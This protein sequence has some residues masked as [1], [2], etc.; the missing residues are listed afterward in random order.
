M[1]F[2]KTISIVLVTLLASLFG[3]CFQQAPNTQQAPSAETL[4]EAASTV[5][6]VAPRVIDELYTLLAYHEDRYPLVSAHR[7]GPAPGFPENAL[8]TFERIANIH[9]VIIECDIQMT[10]DSVLILMHDDKLDRTTDAKGRIADMDY[11][12]LAGVRLRDKDG[13]STDYRIPTLAEALQWG[14]GKV[15]YTLDVKRGVPYQLVVDEIRRNKAEA[16]SVV[17]TYNADQAAEVHALAPELMISASIRSEADL[18]RLNRMGIPNH[19][20]VAFVGT[21][22]ADRATYETLHRAGIS[23]ILGTIGNLDTQAA[24]QGEQRYVQYVRHGADIL[25]TDRP[26]EAGNALQQLAAEKGLSSPFIH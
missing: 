3:A 26:V 25:S 23:T 24:R 18:R 13:A 4:D 7:G 14:L 1:N 6:R 20:L 21:R 5:H 10:R 15:V 12:Q 9:P 22:E 19:V 11:A 2:S 16:I 17:I 8:E